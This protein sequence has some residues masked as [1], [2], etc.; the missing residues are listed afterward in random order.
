MP[1]SLT[2]FSLVVGGGAAITPCMSVMT[3]SQMGSM[4]SVDETVFSEQQLFS[5]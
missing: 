3:H 4:W 1:I 5:Y 2:Y